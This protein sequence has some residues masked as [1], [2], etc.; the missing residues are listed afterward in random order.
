MPRPLPY[1]QLPANSPSH[2]SPRTP[3]QPT[4]RSPIQARPTATS[5][6]YGLEPEA[7]AVHFEGQIDRPS[8]PSSS[9]EPIRPFTTSDPLPVNN[10]R[11]LSASS[12]DPVRP[13]IRI[14]TP[15]PPSVPFDANS[16]GSTSAWLRW[17]GER[18]ARRVEAEGGDSTRAMQNPNDP[19]RR[20]RQSA[21]RL[22]TVESRIGQTNDNIDP[23]PSSEANEAYAESRRLLTE[24]RER[25]DDTRTRIEDAR[26]II[27]N[28]DDQDTRD[29]VAQAR[30]GLDRSVAFASRLR[31]LASTL[32][33]LSE[34]ASALATS[35]AQ[36]PH[37]SVD[38]STNPSS[39]QTTSIESPLSASQTD[40]IRNTVRQLIIA[41]RRVSVAIDRHR[42]QQASASSTSSSSLPQ[43]SNI[44]P[45]FPPTDLPLRISLPS[46]LRSSSYSSATTSS[47]AF[48]PLNVS[49][50]D[51]SPN[52]DGLLLPSRPLTQSPLP[53]SISTSNEFRSVGGENYPGER[54]QLLRIATLQRDIASRALELRELRARGREL[55]REE[56]E[57]RRVRL[58]GGQIMPL[59]AVDPDKEDEEGEGEEHEDTRWLIRRLAREVEVEAYS[60]GDETVT[61]SRK[62]IKEE[63]KRRYE[64]YAVCGR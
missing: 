64:L 34:R 46:P 43:S 55:D 63:Q 45:P 8:F 15:S 2:S 52:P 51:T 62:K 58:E 12:L 31:Q 9:G 44:L 56:R 32:T 35:S 19:L 11:R 6:F 28:E 53:S 61:Q 49:S 24:V 47:Q 36:P 26:S 37:R 23:S 20:L 42:A 17:L 7:V 50:Q 30:L 27:N 5:P 29:S 22:R 25:L 33:D 4:P 54:A 39:S 3:F 10:R 21:E 60:S 40:S 13:Q 48:D 38:S 57:T 1:D 16:E 14:R 41:S 18:R 59:L